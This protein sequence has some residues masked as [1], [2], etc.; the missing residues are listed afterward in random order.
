M[1]GITLHP[2]L[3]WTGNCAAFGAFERRLDV[4]F[5]RGL[6]CFTARDSSSC[7]LI[8][9]S[10]LLELG[11]WAGYDFVATSQREG[12]SSA[13]RKGLRCQRFG[14][15]LTSASVICRVLITVLTS[16]CT[17]AAMVRMLTFRA[18]RKRISSRRSATLASGPKLVA[19]STLL[20]FIP[21]SSSQ[22]RTVDS[23]QSNSSAM[24]RADVP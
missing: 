12:L 13:L 21:S 15:S 8:A 5:L 16:H 19:T 18:P 6:G 3:D 14:Q 23:V 24:A 11:A 7:T 4:A 22:P 2:V 17:A 10:A 9:C 1:A 20:I